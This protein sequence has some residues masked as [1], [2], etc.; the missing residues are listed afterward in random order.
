MITPSKLPFTLTFSGGWDKG[1]RYFNRFT[2]D[3]SELGE[4][5]KPG[6]TFTENQDIYVRFEAPRGFRFTMD[7]LDV[8][9][10]PGQ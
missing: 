8:V 2:E 6:L 9:T 3:P 5:V 1:V 7:G 10:L 4:E